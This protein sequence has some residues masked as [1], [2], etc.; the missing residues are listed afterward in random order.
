MNTFTIHCNS[1]K[2]LTEIDAQNIHRLNFKSFLS[3]STISEKSSFVAYILTSLTL[4]EWYKIMV[5][6]TH[7]LG[8]GGH[9][10]NR[11]NPQPLLTL[12][13]KFLVIQIQNGWVLIPNIFAS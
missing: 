9:L 10:G 4:F 8:N 13:Y 3:F 11:A 2:F 12:L 1:G 6:S 7:T 5:I